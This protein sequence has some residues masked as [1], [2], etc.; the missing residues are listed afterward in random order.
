MKMSFNRSNRAVRAGSS[1]SRT[2]S[3]RR[4]IPDAR[5]V[6]ATAE[7]GAFWYRIWLG[8]RARA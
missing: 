6:A 2:K 1:Y 8:A 3:Y 7:R 4:F 5:P